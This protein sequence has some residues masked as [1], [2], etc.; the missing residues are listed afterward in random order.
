M[1]GTP[2]ILPSR[3]RLTEVQGRKRSFGR[4]FDRLCTVFR[5]RDDGQAIVIDQPA[6]TSPAIPIPAT[7]TIENHRKEWTA[8]HLLPELVVDDEE[9]ILDCSDEPLVSLAS[10]ERVDSCIP[11]AKTRQLFLRHGLT[12]RT[13]NQSEAEPAAKLRRIEKPARMRVRW[14]CHSCRADFGASKICTDCGHQRC[15]M[16][17]REPSKKIKTRDTTEAAMTTIRQPAGTDAR[18]MTASCVIQAIAAKQPAWQ[19]TIQIGRPRA[20]TYS[21][22]TAQHDEL[23][24]TQTDQDEA[25]LS[26]SV[27]AD[28]QPLPSMVPTVERVYKKPRQRVRYNCEHCTTQFTSK[29]ECSGCGHERC[30]NCPR[31]P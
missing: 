28:H 25:C 17:I 4:V 1:S 6:N 22:Q 7:A 26:S 11:E 15:T 20:D 29:H 19:C 10:L 12:Y 30:E 13:R 31:Y 27:L 16:C 5:R 3:P 18:P 14:S 8:S 23:Q 2:S 9:N 21:L 24:H